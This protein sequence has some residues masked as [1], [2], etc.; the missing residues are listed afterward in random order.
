MK[1]CLSL[2][3]VEKRIMNP[4]K[5]MTLRPHHLLCLRFR[6]AEFPD[7]PG[8]FLETEQTVK[9]ALRPESEVMIRAAKGV[10]MLCLTCP[11]CGAGRCNDPQ[12]NE[13]VIRERDAMILK[14]L[15]VSYGAAMTSKE[16]DDLIARKAP[17]D[18]CL[19]Q[20]P[21]KAECPAQPKKTL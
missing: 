2:V 21:A 6:P 3:E 5:T 12:G 10:D 1:S 19:T 17:L 13:E 14:G 11:N 4:I 20:C 8:K 18:F 9:A 7:R 16:W 15:G